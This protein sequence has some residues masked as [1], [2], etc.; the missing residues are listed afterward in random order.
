MN[1]NNIHAFIEVAA[2]G[3]FNRAADN[4]HVTQS[5]VSARIKSLETDIG[6]AL[7]DRGHA[8]ARLT[9]AG[10]QFRQYALGMQQ[11]WQQAHQAVTLRRGFHG[12]LGIGAQVSLWEQLILDWI[13]WMRLRL[14]NTALRIEA[15]Y[16]TSLMRQLHDGLLDIGVMYQPR[17][18]PG[19]KVEMLL[20]ETLVMVS[21]RQRALQP[22]WVEDYVYVDWGDV[23]RARHGEAFPDME[24]PAVSVGLGALGLQYIV[25]NGGSGYFPLRVVLPKIEAGQLFRLEGA[26]VIHRPAYVVYRASHRE[27]EVQRMA[28]EGLRQIAR[29]ESLAEQEH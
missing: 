18:T 12:M 27:P 1:L 11:L 3:N 9:P 17:Q 4:L 22:G 20:E 5:T 13:P 28:L 29:R 8:G 7:F 23:Y 14:P 15:D 6:M 26:P 19:L 25:R 16:S 10:Q 2:T 24:T 21:T